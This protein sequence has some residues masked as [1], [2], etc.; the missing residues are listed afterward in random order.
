MITPPPPFDDAQAAI[1]EWLFRQECKFLAGATDLK[2]IP[3]MISV[4]EVAF[5]G[6]SNVGKSSLVN[7][8]TGR[9]TLA[10]VSQTPGRTR[11]LNFFSLADKLLL[12]DL[13]GYGY[14]SAPKHMVAS[15]NNLIKGY[16][17]GRAS[18]SRVMLLIDARHGLKDVD[19]E[20]ME[21]LDDT[22]VSYQI[23]FTKRDK[24]SQ[25]EMDI[26]VSRLNDLAL[27]HTALYP[28][29]LTTSSKEDVGLKELRA[30]LTAIAT[31]HSA[32]PLK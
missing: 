6:R 18:L 5:V 11:Q 25:A 4:P 19:K 7:A 32:T 12:V 14:A 8:L 10:K 13:P 1:A 15:W 21:M 31:E 22:A 9:K 27:K 17:R 16:L 29:Y 26:N 3:S 23:I 2:V 20:V 24:S 28:F 30:T